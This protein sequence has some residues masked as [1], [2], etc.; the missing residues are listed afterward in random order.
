MVFV[1]RVIRCPGS[2]VLLADGSAEGS[3]VLAPPAGLV[4]SQLIHLMSP[5]F[6]LGLPTTI[7]RCMQG[8]SQVLNYGLRLAERYFALVALTGP[9]WE[10][11]CRTQ[12]SGR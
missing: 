3:T 10:R 2:T 9:D 4:M 7:F 11:S 6:S 1:T 8:C 12:P 5:A